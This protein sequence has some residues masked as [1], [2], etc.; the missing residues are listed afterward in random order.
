MN[1]LYENIISFL[2]IFSNEVKDWKQL[3]NENIKKL[4][5]QISKFS[6]RAH[7]SENN[8]ISNLESKLESN[9]ESKLESNLES[10]LESNLESN[11]EFKNE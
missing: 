4:E 3:K 10:K 9:L 8:F 7:S 2:T 5:S 11:L 6:L 1:W